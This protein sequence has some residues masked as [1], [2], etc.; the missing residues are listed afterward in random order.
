[1][2][3]LFGDI[4]ASDPAG[5]GRR[6]AVITLA[7]R[8]DFPTAWSSL[9]CLD[10]QLST[11]RRRFVLLND[12]PDQKLSE[13]LMTLPHTGLIQPGENLG[14][15]AG[16]NLLIERA[17]DWGADLIVTLDDDLLVPEDYLNQVENVMGPGS[18]GPGIATPILLDYHHLAAS[19]Q[20]PDEI[21]AV[22]EGDASLSSSMTTA[23]IFDAWGRLDSD[24]R[25][26]AVHHM[27]IRNWRRHYF[28]PLGDTG[29]RVSG[30][31]ADVV[32][33][34]SPT[35]ALPGQT[36]LREDETAIAAAL[37]ESDP[38]SIDSAPGGSTIYRRS[39]VEA[40]GLLEEAFSPFGYEDAEICI[41]AKRSGLEVALLRSVVLLHDLQSRNKKRDPLIGV[42]TRAKARVLLVRLHSDDR[43]VAA[44]RVFE[45]LVVGSLEAGMYSHAKGGVISAALAYFAG[46]LAGV[47][48]PLSSVSPFGPTSRS[49]I[50]PYITL[51]R[52]ATYLSDEKV[53]GLLP[54]V[55]SGSALFTV[56]IR[57][58]VFSG[59]L[60]PVLS[61]RVSGTYRLDA[62]G[63]LAVDDLVVLI[64]GLFR[65][66]VSG[67]IGGV[68][69]DGRAVDPIESTV[70]HSLEVRATDSGLIDA[71]ENTRAWL[72]GWPSNGLLR[73]LAKNVAGDAGA[74][75]REFLS[76][77][78]SSKVLTIRMHP[79]EPV[80]INDLKETA[81]GP[82]H[83]SKTLGL[84]VSCDDALLSAAAMS[85]DS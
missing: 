32:D 42:A 9:H 1:M 56:P 47:F 38:L 67:L 8:G 34:R 62:S 6:M 39:T 69:V 44:T 81:G 7:Q 78:S 59:S 41:R 14:V 63:L 3:R 18:S 52:P 25:N 60:P 72:A 23:D 82:W 45:S 48:A 15:A 21:Q 36:E 66:E 5:G 57:S 65:L 19:L 43:S 27:G 35:A 51:H 53:D 58:T 37:Q 74:A 79:P 4:E 29:R 71:F 50:S 85:A 70:I 73:S 80:G 33:S 28:T 77:R 16:R 10:K 22:E 30:A 24:G 68:P 40:I 17:L 83:V 55:F 12:V 2:T 20:Q 26:E 49:D 31:L 64:P 46:A 76:P 75:I 13:Q 54:R 84:T 11:R 61:G